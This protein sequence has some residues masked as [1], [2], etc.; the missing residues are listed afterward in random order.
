MTPILYEIKMASIV[1]NPRMMVTIPTY[2]LKFKDIVL[3][4][5][6]LG[7]EATIIAIPFSLSVYFFTRGV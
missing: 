1:G 7:I 5:I 6:R 3:G 4:L 2:K